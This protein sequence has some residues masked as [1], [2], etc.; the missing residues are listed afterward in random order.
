MTPENTKIVPRC[1]CCGR[2]T[3]DSTVESY[4]DP[5]TNVGVIYRRSVC[6]KCDNVEYWEDVERQCGAEVYG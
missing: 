5:T 2:F 4:M 6:A 1:M 3:T